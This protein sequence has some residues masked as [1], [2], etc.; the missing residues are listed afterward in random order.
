[1]KIRPV[2]AKSLH[3]DGRT[4]RH[5]KLTFA[6]TDAQTYEANIRFDGRADIRS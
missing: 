5:T 4:R 3:V 6:L 1:M 2:G